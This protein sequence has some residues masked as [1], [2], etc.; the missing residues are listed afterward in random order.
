MS[1]FL[2]YILD[3]QF[4]QTWVETLP[5][6]KIFQ[7]HDTFEDCELSDIHD[8]VQRIAEVKDLPL[9]LEIKAWIFC[10][11]LDDNQNSILD[12][13]CKILK[14]NI[15]SN[16]IEITI[17]NSTKSCIVSKKGLKENLN[18]PYKSRI[19]FNGNN[20]EVLY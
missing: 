17:C 2:E 8:F 9:V 19:D 4:F 14:R 20:N 15:P 16:L 6:L 18:D 11:N 1:S 12:E 10:K 13:C 3:A 5:N 7:L